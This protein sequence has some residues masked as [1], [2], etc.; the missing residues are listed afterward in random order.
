MKFEELKKHLSSGTLRPAYICVGDDAFVLQK[1]EGL[2][3]SLAPAMP[4]FNV[5]VFSETSDST[6]ILDACESLPVIDPLRVVL[7]K[8]FKGDAS[9]FSVYLKKPN[10]STALVF[11][12]QSLK[13]G[14]SK[15]IGMLEPVDCNRLEN[16]FIMN[17][18]AKTVA[19]AGSSVQRDAAELLIEYCDS[20][21]TR[22]ATETEKLALYK[23]GGVITADD[24]KNLVKPETDYKIFELSEAVANKQNVKAAKV[25]NTLLDDKL[26]P[27]AILGMIYS[28]FRRLLYCAITPKD[29]NIA[30]LLGVKEY[31]VKKAS[32][33]AG[34]Y[35][36]KRLMKICDGFHKADA[37]F[38]SGKMTDL[39]ALEVTVMEILNER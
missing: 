38:K 22:I 3:K 16:R 1:A 21:M 10:P 17:Y 37:D 26:A 28:H 19:A 7:V 29:E 32:E 31:A 25:L 12:A 9:K 30:G 18:I 6:A 8:N 24:V 36:P 5:S 11:S 33:Q 20:Y 15:V 39:T 35:T 34:K 14:F 27:S 23:L 2:F 4:D 13:E